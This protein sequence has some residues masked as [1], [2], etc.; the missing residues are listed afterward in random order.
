[1]NAQARKQGR[2]RRAHTYPLITGRIV[3]H[4]RT[5][6]HA[7]TSLRWDNVPKPHVERP[8]LLASSPK[9]AGRKPKP[10]GLND[11]IE[12]AGGVQT[13][14]Q[15]FS[16]AVRATASAC[17][18]PG[19]GRCSTCKAQGVTLWQI[20]GR[21]M[22]ARCRSAGKIADAAQ[23]AHGQQPGYPKAPRKEGTV[24]IATAEKDVAWAARQGRQDRKT[25][26]PRASYKSFLKRYNLRKSEKTWEMWTAYYR[27]SR[28]TSA[29]T[30][31][32]SLSPS[33]GPAPSRSSALSYERMERV[34]ELQRKLN[35]PEAIRDAWR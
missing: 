4:P 11:R 23:P 10:A 21:L 32:K 15:D 25:R 18:K 5:E 17:T 2:N 8:P 9:S 14:Q 7:M 29:S 3:D 27:S 6:M 20:A 33:K 30:Q 13:E 24:I 34:R 12:G 28:Q 31:R 35:P 19:S 1:V 26:T 16:L 22:C